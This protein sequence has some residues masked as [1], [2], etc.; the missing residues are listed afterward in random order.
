MAKTKRGGRFK[1][2]QT[3]TKSPARAQT[4]ER[5]Q[6][7]ER[8]QTPDRDQTPSPQLVASRPKVNVVAASP[9]TSVS[10]NTSGSKRRGRKVADDTMKRKKKRNYNFYGLYIHKVLNQIDFQGD[11]VGIN[12]KAMLVVNDMLVDIYERLVR[13]AVILH[14]R[15]KSKTLTSRD[16]QSATRFIFTGELSKH[17]MKEATEAVRRYHASTK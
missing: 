11:K 1:S 15:T 13:E 2:S 16:F 9:N 5:A 4:P 6:S 3:K 7:P 12:K 14:K 10:P 8:D 17:A